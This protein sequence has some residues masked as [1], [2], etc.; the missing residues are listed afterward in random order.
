MCLFGLDKISPNS[1][2]VQLLPGNDSEANGRKNIWQ[3]PL[4][5]QLVIALLPSVAASPLPGAAAQD[6]AG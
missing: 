4:F 1:A 3:L 6:A 2:N 5:H